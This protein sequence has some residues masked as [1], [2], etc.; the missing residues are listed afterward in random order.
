MA[1]RP[2]FPDA[3]AP[4]GE[5]AARLPRDAR[6][7]VGDHAPAKVPRRRLEVVVRA[8][9]E[10]KVCGK[11][12]AHQL[13]HRF[14][15]SLLAFEGREKC[16]STWKIDTVQRESRAGTGFF[17]DV[18]FTKRTESR[19]LLFEIGSI[20]Q[21]WYATVYEAASLDFDYEHHYYSGRAGRK[22]VAGAHSRRLLV[23]QRLK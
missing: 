4:D 20:A 14:D 1:L 16:R 15:W 3:A 19:M 6:R 5:A 8:E 21:K 10:G 11:K 7:D 18:D 17:K 9:H 12:S 2:L 22:E 13:L 23:S